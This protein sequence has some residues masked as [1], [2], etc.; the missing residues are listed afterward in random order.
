LLKFQVD[1]NQGYNS[2]PMPSTS[3]TIDICQ[4]LSNI[5]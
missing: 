3:T 5:N 4:V 2:F 1:I